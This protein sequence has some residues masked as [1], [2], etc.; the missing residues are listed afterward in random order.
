MPGLELAP[1]PPGLGLESLEA[2]LDLGLDLVRME[3]PPLTLVRR[4][5]T[6]IIFPLSCQY[7]K[8]LYFQL[9]FS[10]IKDI[11]IFNLVD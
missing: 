5:N 9:S 11:I 2:P 7:S 4:I 8:R 6:H 1:M 10:D 3:P